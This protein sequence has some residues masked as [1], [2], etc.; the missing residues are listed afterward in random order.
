MKIAKIRNVNNV[1]GLKI[2][3]SN[4][5]TFFIVLWSIIFLSP[6]PFIPSI[7]IAF[8]QPN[9]HFF[10]ESIDDIFYMGTFINIFWMFYLL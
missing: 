10:D 2:K 6:I 5:T 4:L 3:Q 8:W 9:N 1:R 7:I